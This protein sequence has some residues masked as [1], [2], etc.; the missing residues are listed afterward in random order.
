MSAPED[1]ANLDNRVEIRAPNTAFLKMIWWGCGWGFQR[2]L[3][4]IGEFK[5]PIQLSVNPDL[6]ANWSSDIS[7]GEKIYILCVIKHS[8]M[9]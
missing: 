1:M 4:N 8:T 2:V 3:V 6:N 9:L 5:A 7:I